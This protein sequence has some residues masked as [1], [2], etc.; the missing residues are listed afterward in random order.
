MK[1]LISWWK[2]ST[3]V[4]EDATASQATALSEAKD[5]SA[6][7]AVVEAWPCGV[8]AELMGWAAA[9]AFAAL[10]S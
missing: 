10:G 3:T 2:T 4:S 7:Q 5:E 9:G 1:Q 6:H 8:N